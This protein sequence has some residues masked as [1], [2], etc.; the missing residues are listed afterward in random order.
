MVNYSTSCN[1][2]NL[3]FWAKKKYGEMVLNTVNKLLRS[4]I[5]KKHLLLDHRTLND[6]NT[7]HKVLKDI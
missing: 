2:S 1:K 5:L 3:V 7:L 4:Q 6:K